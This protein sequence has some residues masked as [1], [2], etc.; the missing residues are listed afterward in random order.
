MEHK[1]KNM[2]LKGIIVLVPIIIIVIS[3]FAFYLYMDKRQADILNKQTR[4]KAFGDAYITVYENPNGREDIQVYS[5]GR[6]LKQEIYLHPTTYYIIHKNGDAY[7]FY[8]SQTKNAITNK[9][10][11]VSLE[12]KRTFDN[13][14]LEKIENKLKLVMEEHKNDET[15]VPFGGWYIKINGEKTLVH[16]YDIYTE[17]LR[18]YYDTNEI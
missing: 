1:K 16:N 13:S 17:V 8:E 11:P 9:Y 14:E 10:S 5:E 18:E 3:A 6:G 2:L 15:I 7:T 4:Q 12:Y